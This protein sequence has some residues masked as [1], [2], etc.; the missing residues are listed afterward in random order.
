MDVVAVFNPVVENA[1]DPVERRV[2]GEK[3]MGLRSMT[4]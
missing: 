1:L 3:K 4:D 2:P